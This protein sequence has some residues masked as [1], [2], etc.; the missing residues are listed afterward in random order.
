MLVLLLR[1]PH[2]GLSQPAS[3]EFKK[4]NEDIQSLKAGQKAI[5]NELQELKKHLAV[6]GEERAPV[7]DIATTL[8][9]ADAFVL[10]DTQA[11]LALVE[12]TDYQ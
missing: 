4:L 2:V 10:G 8:S 11:R 9:L 7:R 12:F 3:D 1:T 5:L 6:R